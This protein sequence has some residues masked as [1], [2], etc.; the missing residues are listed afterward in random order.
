[1][2]ARALSVTGGQHLEDRRGVLPQ[3]ALREAPL[4][5]RRDLA[6][7]GPG[8]AL[9]R[10]RTETTRRCRC[11]YTIHFSSMHLSFITIHRRLPQVFSIRLS[12]HGSD[13]AV[14]GGT[15]TGK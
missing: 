8:V 7:L 5:R 15:P 13:T 6:D 4:H 9:R 2:Q 11:S 14:L 1:M 10:Q 12:A 3:A